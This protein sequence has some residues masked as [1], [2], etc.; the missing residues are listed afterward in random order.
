MLKKFCKSYS[1]LHSI[2][3]VQLTSKKK[4][5]HQ[6]FSLYFKNCK[7]IIWALEIEVIANLIRSILFQDYKSTN[8]YCEAIK[9]LIIK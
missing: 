9:T 1:N 2:K 7:N 3:Q 5:L 6:K 8:S 4:Q